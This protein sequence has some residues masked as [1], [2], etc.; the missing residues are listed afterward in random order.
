ML[1]RE[2]L[3]Q[4]ENGKAPNLILKGNQNENGHYAR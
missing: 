1:K 3:W 2:A 4:R